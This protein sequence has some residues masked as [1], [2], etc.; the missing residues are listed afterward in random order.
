MLAGKAA[1]DRG[2]MLDTVASPQKRLSEAMQ[3]YVPVAA[4]TLP[5]VRTLDVA[6]AQS[7]TAGL[8]N[9]TVGVT[10]LQQTRPVDPPGNYS[11]DLLF[12]AISGF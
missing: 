8:L 2:H 6:G 3:A 12:S 9:Q 1:I 4:P 11:I 10:I 5:L 7:L